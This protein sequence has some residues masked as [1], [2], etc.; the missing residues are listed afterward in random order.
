MKL[1]RAA[2][3]IACLTLGSIRPVNVIAQ[4]AD[5][6]QILDL[7]A[8]G[9]ADEAWTRWNALPPTADTLR[10]GVRLAIATR[11]LPRAID[12]YDRLAKTMGTP[13]RAS[14]STLAVAVADSLA[15]DPDLDARLPACA[16]AL[17]LQ[18]SDAICR[19]GID[20]FVKST[21]ADE[22]AFAYYS[23][24]NSGIRVSP[25]D[26]SAA[27]Q[28]MGTAMRLRIARIMSRVPAADRVFILQPVLTDPD[29][30]T[31]YQGLL[32]LGAIPGE[33]AATALRRERSAAQAPPL[34]TAVLIGLARHGDT[35]SIDAL[36]GLL[37]VLDGYEKAQAAA[38]LAQAKRN[39]GL[40]QLAGSLDRGAEL[41]RLAAAEAAA[42]IQPEAARR[43]IIDIL[44][45]GSPAVRQRA[46]IVAG[47][48]GLGTDPAVYR[49]LSDFSPVIRAA[50]VAAIQETL[51]I[52]TRGKARGQ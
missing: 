41:E 44:T 5:Q 47:S 9:R 49:R 37:P 40:T 48:L 50:A 26:L 7:A 1:R 32:V 10:L 51:A 42:T 20:E 27:Q 23:L 22:R 6:I 15:A 13:D 45:A 24:F 35:E 11:Q 14:L 19:K 29:V 4:T 28:N 18:P 52:D 30:A 31:R 43:V 36:A 46:L 16:A 39:T 8:T 34:K 25:S 21:D 12:L 33:E 38:A 2:A 3:L 17:T